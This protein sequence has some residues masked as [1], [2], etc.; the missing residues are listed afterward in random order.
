MKKIIFILFA[1]VSWQYTLAQQ[2]IYYNGLNYNITSPTTVEVGV[3]S[4][5]TGAVMIPSQIFHY[6]SNYTV[7]SI[8]NNAF[9]GCQQLIS[10]SIPNSVTSIGHGRQI[11]RSKGGQRIGC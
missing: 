6:I 5:A 4:G 8:S 7:T 9:Q 11:D 2:Q 3:N 1:V 10:V